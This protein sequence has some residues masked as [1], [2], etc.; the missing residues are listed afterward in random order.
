MGFATLQDIKIAITE[1][2]TEGTFVS[3][4]TG[5]QFIQVLNGGATLETSKEILERDLLGGGLTK[6]SSRTGMWSAAG[7][8]NVEMKANGVEG[9]LTEYSLLMESALGTKRQAV[10]KTTSDAD[11]GT[12]SD[13]VICFATADVG[14]YNVGDTLHIKRAGA[15][16]LSPIV[17]ITGTEVTLLIADPAGAFVDGITVSALTTYSPADDGH[18]AISVSRY[19]GTA[20]E[21]GVGCKVTSMNL[22]SF[23][24]GKTAS[25]EFGFEGLYPEKAVEAIPAAPTF[26]TALPPIILSAC[27]YQDTVKLPINNLSLSLTNELGFVTSTCSERG[28][29][30]SRVTSRTIEGSINPNKSNN[31]LEQWSKF[32]ANTEYSIFGYALAPTAV[33]GEYQ[34]IVS[35]YMPHCVSVELS[36]GENSGLLLDEISFKAEGGSAQS[37]ELFISIL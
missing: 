35:F 16:H 30:S 22:A 19:V 34:D 10:T 37:D 27:L 28:K 24:T 3:A 5:D 8:L 4:T 21:K 20:L 36:E 17:D 23:E 31:T 6:A 11:G 9:A 13:T 15:H 18:K 26:D 2:V 7:N 33:T 32:E 25:F 14:V 1:E 12:Y 29:I